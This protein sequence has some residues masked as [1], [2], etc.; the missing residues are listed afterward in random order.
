NIR[1][2]NILLYNPPEFGRVYAP[3]MFQNPIIQTQ[4]ID[5]M[6]TT[7]KSI[8]RPPEVA[9]ELLW[10]LLS[11]L[12]EF[13]PIKRFAADQ[14]LKHP[15]FTSSEANADI[16]PEQHKLAQFAQKLKLSGQQITQYN[17]NPSFI[18]SENV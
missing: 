1:C 7:L 2:S 10:D 16:S 4:R 13:D 6:M 18:V 14:A 5:M 11:K 3:E 9:D 17:V 8:E 12:L 15:Y